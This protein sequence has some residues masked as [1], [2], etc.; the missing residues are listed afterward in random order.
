MITLIAFHFLRLGQNC[1]PFF[2]LTQIMI[3]GLSG[4][5]RDQTTNGRIKGNSHIIFFMWEHNRFSEK[6]VKTVKKFV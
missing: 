1:G 6:K 5:Y 4:K 3:S 2:I